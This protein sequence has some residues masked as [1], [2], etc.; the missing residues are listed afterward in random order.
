MRAGWVGLGKLGYPCALALAAYGGHDVLGYDPAVSGPRADLREAGLAEAERKADGRLRFAVSAA[1]VVRECDV[2]VI[3]VQTPHAAEY[4]G[5]RPA[6]ETARDFDYRWLT[7][8]VRDVVAEAERQERRITVV[9]LSTTLPGTMDRLIRPL[10]GLR[11]TLAYSPAFISLGTTIAD[12]CRPDFIISATADGSP[13]PAL[14]ELY[15]FTGAPLVPCT[16]VTGELIKVARNMLI[17]SQITFAN[18]IMEIAH[19]TGADADAVTGALG[20]PRT[21][22]MADGGPC[23][24][25]DLIALSWLS[26]QLGLSFDLAGALGRA[27]EAQTAWLAGIVRQHAEDSGLPVMILGRAYKPESDLTAGSPALLL[28]HYLGA[29]AWDPLLDGPHMIGSRPRVFAVATRH[30]QF[31]RIRFPAGS[32]VVDPFGYIPDAPGVTVDRV[33]RP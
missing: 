22:G 24:P 12:F 17:T 15:A 3:A 19:K 31:A 18:M 9:V 25:R 16:L 27:R 20:L 30:P 7:A 11:V 26:G 33:G 4:G 6:P 10:R 32:V 28:R 2:V 23:R 14:E 1:E 29:V 13:V 8:A 5:E 21:A